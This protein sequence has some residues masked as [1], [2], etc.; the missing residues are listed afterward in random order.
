MAISGE[1]LAGLGQQIGQSIAA[2]AQFRASI[3]QQK[4]KDVQSEKE[5]NI[6]R[7]SVDPSALVMS[8]F[9]DVIK[10]ADPQKKAALQNRAEYL[11]TELDRQMRLK[12]EYQR[13]MLD[14]N[15]KFVDTPPQKIVLQPKQ[16]IRYL[17]EQDQ[18]PA[19]GK[20]GNKALAWIGNYF[21]KD[22]KT[23][24]PEDRINNLE[25]L[26]DTMKAN[27]NQVPLYASTES[28]VG[29]E[30][31]NAFID[32]AKRHVNEP[33]FDIEGSMADDWSTWGPSGSYNLRGKEGSKIITPEKELKK[34]MKNPPPRKYKI[35]DKINTVDGKKTV[36]GFDSAGNPIAK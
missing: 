8:A 21:G 14:P 24:T 26:R 19:A 17:R 27:M 2:P 12:A 36:T 22:W 18:L 1:E 33:D 16:I 28:Y 3:E 9:D 13:R 31:I 34:K 6:K 20:S 15:G 10:E 32:E 35:G 11:A 5:L 23:S 25:Q 29:R 30:N 4:Y 7:Q